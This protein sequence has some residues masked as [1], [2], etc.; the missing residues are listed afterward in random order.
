MQ[1]LILAACRFINY[2]CLKKKRAIMKILR[3][4]VLIAK[5]WGR[6][7]CF[8]SFSLLSV[9]CNHASAQKAGDVIS[10]TI[11]DDAG[12]VWMANICERDSLNRIVAHSVSD[13]CGNFAFRLVNPDNKIDVTHIGHERVDLPI[14]RTHY[15]IKMKESESIPKVDVSTNR[16]VET[17]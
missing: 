2:F 9:V 10:G 5:G 12:P 6:A 17:K 8:V 3:L 13:T 15:E 7:L 4:R 16:K 1:R 14:D 11:T